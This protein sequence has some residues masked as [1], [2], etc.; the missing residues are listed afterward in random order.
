MR[1]GTTGETSMPKSKQKK[2]E[3]QQYLSPASLKR[4]TQQSNQ[5]S[6]TGC[7]ERERGLDAYRLQRKFSPHDPLYN[8]TDEELLKLFLKVDESYS[9]KIIQNPLCYSCLCSFPP[10]EIE[11]HILICIFVRRRILTLHSPPLNRN[12]NGHASNGGNNGAPMKSSNGASA[13]LSAQNSNS[14]FSITIT[15]SDGTCASSNNAN[16]YNPREREATAN[17]RNES[18][19]SSSVSEDRYINSEDVMN[20]TPDD[21]L[22]SFI[23]NKMSNS[24]VGAI[25]KRNSS[26]H[27]QTRTLL[28]L[29]MFLKFYEESNLYDYTK[30]P[31]MFFNGV[32]GTWGPKEVDYLINKPTPNDA[33]GRVVVLRHG[34][35]YHNQA[36]G[37]HS[38]FQRDAELNIVGV[39]QAKLIGSLF[40][41][42]TGLFDLDS[43]NGRL[44]FVVSPFT[45]T[46]QTLVHLMGKKEWDIPTIIQPLCA[47]HTLEW[48][49]VQQGDRGS[50]P[51]KLR[52]LFPVDQYPQFDFDPVSKYCLKRGIANGQWW[53]HNSVAISETEASFKRR[54]V[55]FKRWLAK[56]YTKHNYSHILVVSHGGF[57]R[58]SFDN[59]K[60]DNCE[61]RVFDLK[62]DGSYIRGEDVHAPHPT[63]LRVL[64]VENAREKDSFQIIGTLLKESEKVQFVKVLSAS[65]LTEMV[66]LLQASPNV[67]K[68]RRY[69]TVSMEKK[70]SVFVPAKTEL[71]AW[72]H[73][74]ALAIESCVLEKEQF[75]RITK[76]F[77]DA[78]ITCVAPNSRLS[79]SGSGQPTPVSNAAIPTMEILEVN[80]V[81]SYV[82]IYSEVKYSISGKFGDAD[83]KK[84]CSHS[85]CY[86]TLHEGIIGRKPG[87][88]TEDVYRKKFHTR[89]P[90]KVS[91]SGL[92]AWLFVFASVLNSGILGPEIVERVRTFLL[93]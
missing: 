59:V 5:S 70:G 7:E 88:M 17:S 93:S 31:S 25:Q 64:D 1:R 40:R 52:Q 55:E 34:M 4:S 53:H 15:N 8:L 79:A 65:E 81:S 29:D 11:E 39:E 10:Q 73:Q 87:M 56:M 83:F 32:K 78:A 76:V 91:G 92:Y 58:H 84:V 27:L 49:V 30:F 35:G 22:S 13:K 28:G 72:L 80:M 67:E 57:L 20:V 63:I 44:L 6:S 51:Q 24:G 2:Q 12:S 43:Y 90:D 38:Y 14:N 33:A 86:S 77:G 21:R 74:L 48:S 46:L 42:V 62:S 85:E 36:Y 75:E 41:N 47:E 18:P 54:T 71:V 89:F 45:R 68:I 16:A 50:T 82:P 9:Q 19:H 3:Q 66:Q 23:N 26:A 60:F 37:S 69:I 61:F